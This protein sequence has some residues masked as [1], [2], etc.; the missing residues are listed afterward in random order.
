MEGEIGGLE[1]GLEEESEVAGM[2]GETYVRSPPVAQRGYHYDDC[3]RDMTVI[4]ENTVPRGESTKLPNKF[5][6]SISSKVPIQ[7]HQY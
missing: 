6:R 1:E 4:S 5:S 7:S 2:S 3:C